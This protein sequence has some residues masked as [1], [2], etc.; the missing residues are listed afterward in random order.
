MASNSLDYE[1]EFKHICEEFQA[2]SSPFSILNRFCSTNKFLTQCER[3]N[4]TKATSRKECYIKVIWWFF[5]LFSHKLV[6]VF[7]KRTN[8]NMRHGLFRTIKEILPRPFLQP[9]GLVKR[10]KGGRVGREW[11]A[12]FSWTLPLTIWRHIGGCIETSVHGSPQPLK[13]LI[14][15]TV[16]VPSSLGVW[17]PS[18]IYGMAEMGWK[19]KAFLLQCIYQTDKPNCLW[20]LYMIKIMAA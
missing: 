4:C 13:Y 8:K 5:V 6:V 17:Y 16:T 12:Y 20:T 14:L 15:Q 2:G 10:Q 7:L 11:G 18:F 3:M 19:K 1:L 9:E